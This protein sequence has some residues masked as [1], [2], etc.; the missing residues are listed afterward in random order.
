MDKLFFSTVEVSQ[1]LK[2]LI[3]AGGILPLTI[4]GSSMKPLLKH[5][6]DIVYLHVCQPHDMKR[7]RIV[8]FEREDRSLILHRIRRVLPDGKLLMNGDSQVWCETIRPDQVIAVAY[9]I[10]RKGKEIP[11]DAFVLRCWDFIWFPTRPIRPLF[12]ALVRMK[13]CMFKKFKTAGE[14]EE[15]L[16]MK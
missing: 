11:C 7:G 13:K 10:Q 9:Q 3:Q 16:W 4:S 1:D 8:L 12:V 14:E 5:G 6:R 15:S 2:S